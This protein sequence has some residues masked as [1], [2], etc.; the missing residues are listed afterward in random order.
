MNAKSPS[1]QFYAAA[2]YD[3]DE[4]E[5]ASL[6]QQ[7][8]YQDPMFRFLCQRR[9][10]HFARQL[11]A[12]FLRM[13]RIHRN[14]GGVSIAIRKNHSQSEINAIAQFKLPNSGYDSFQLLWQLAAIGLHCGVGCLQRFIKIGQAMPANWPRT[15]HVYVSVLAV[16]PQHQGNGY[17]AYLLDRVWETSKHHRD[18]L[19]VCLDTQ[20]PNNLAYYKRHGFKIIGECQI[21]D[22][23]SWCLYRAH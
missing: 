19:G 10:P 1:R 11:L 7:A 17:G 14:N 2:V 8:F 3:H 13:Q 6:C 23:Q 4:A 18:S 21:E 9:D 16:A 5:I 15:P 12:L 20:N 22:L